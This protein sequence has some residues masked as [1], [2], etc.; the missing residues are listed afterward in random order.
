MFVVDTNS[1][2]SSFQRMD[3]NNPIVTRSNLSKQNSQSPFNDAF[4]VQDQGANLFVP[5][6]I[7]STLTVDEL[8]TKHYKILNNDPL[9]LGS[10]KTIVIEAG[11]ST[12]SIDS[13]TPQYH[14]FTILNPTDFD[15]VLVFN[16]SQL[17]TTSLFGL[18]G[19]LI[20]NPNGSLTNDFSFISPNS[21]ASFDITFPSQALTTFNFYT[22][23]VP[24][25]SPEEIPRIV[26]VLHQNQI[27]FS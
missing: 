6:Q 19:V 7:E 22:K 16:F 12:I 2:T 14:Q 11:T 13:T 21:N 8:G 26:A 27:M 10:R 18:N 4:I 5:T 3:I 24:D 20:Y 17:Q 9:V 15:I 23:P 25:Q 1:L